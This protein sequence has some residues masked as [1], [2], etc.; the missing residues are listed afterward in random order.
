M[1]VNLPFSPYAATN[2]AGSFNVDSTGYVQGEMLPNA[3][4]RQFLTKGFLASGQTLPMWGGVAISEN[5]PGP[6]GSATSPSP[7]LGGP[8]GRATTVS[9]GAGQI[10][11]FSVFDQNYSAV[12]NPQSP[13][14]LVGTFGQVSF[15]RFGSGIIIPVAMD[16]DLVSLENEIITTQVSWDF[17]NQVLQPF[18]STATYA[19]T[20]MTWSAANGGQIAIVAAEATPVGAVGD[21]VF[22]SGAT[23]SGTGGNSVVN[24]TFVVT[25]FTNNENFVV[26]APAAA[27]VIGTIAGTPLLNF[28]TGALPVRVVGVEIGK[29]MTVNF[30]AASGTANWNRQGSTALIIL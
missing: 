6:P 7:L 20:S 1:A 8:V 15:F 10:T 29:S 22:I 26:A 13:V 5:I 24:G 30:N 28:G 25:A 21:S 3:A 19:L 16:P 9:A 4:A 27:G 23:N 14:P 18:N 12:N 2:A 11:G 17:N